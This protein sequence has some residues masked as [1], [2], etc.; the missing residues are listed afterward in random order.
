MEGYA[1]FSFQNDTP[2]TKISIILPCYNEG[3]TLSQL[4]ES[5]RKVSHGLDEVELILV[6]NGSTDNTAEQLKAEKN[7]N[8]PL[9]LKIVT[10][11]QNIGYGH[12]IMKGISHASGDYIAWSHADL[13]CPSEDVVRLYDEVMKRPNPKNCFGK[14]YRINKVGRAAFF[15]R[16]QTLLSLLILGYH[17][18]EIY[19]Q[20][21]LFHRDFVNNFHA[22]PTGYELDFYAFYKATMNKM[23][24]VTID[25]YFH[26]RKAGKSKWAYSLNSRLRFI[27]NNF[28]YLLHLRLKGK[29]I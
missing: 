29:K 6:D 24:I 19:A 16:I 14:G 2:M 20:P 11:P 18:K 12:G 17:L 15:T 22:P 1:T 4:V 9:S 10:V 21:K 13:Q 23:D 27:I 28:S 3:A 5:Y 7:K 8:N 25:V 26:E